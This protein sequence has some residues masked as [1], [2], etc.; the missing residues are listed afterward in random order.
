[1]NPSTAFATVVVDELIRCGRAGGGAGAGVAQCAA[2]VGAGRCRP[3]RAAATARADRRAYRGVPGDRADPRHRSAGAGRDDVRYCGGQPAPGCARGVAQRAAADRAERG[4]AA[5]AAGEW[6]EPD[7]R[8]A[9]GVRR[10]RAAV[11]RDRYAVG[12]SSARWPTGGRW[13]PGPSRWPSAPVPRI[14]GRCSSTAPWS[15]RWCRT[16]SRRLAGVAGRPE[17]GLD[18]RAAGAAQPSA[19][20]PGPK[21][22]VVAGD[23]ASQAARLAAEA[24]NWPL[25]AEPSSRSRIGPAVISAYRL[26]LAAFLGG[27]DRA[28]A[29]VRPPD[30]VPADLQAAG[31]RGRRGDRGRADRALAGRRP[32]GRPVVTGAGGHRRRRHRLAG[33]VAARGRSWPVPR[34]TRSRRRPHRTG[35]SPRWSARR[36]VPTACSWSPPRTRSAT[37]TWRPVVPIR[38]VANRGLAGIDGTLSTAVG[39]ALANAGADVRAG[40]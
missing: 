31:A 21:T 38:T 16:S 9:Q 34:S 17:C 8:P 10:R 39:A 11:P 23:G 12:A 15:N 29:G 14:P 18:E 2:G 28:G 40:R 27:R 24:G 4:P 22:V 37:S 33:P 35:G 19:V 30:A 5:G 26:L 36:S 7:D 32:P 20:A 13:S 3:R 25:F 1:M 6:G